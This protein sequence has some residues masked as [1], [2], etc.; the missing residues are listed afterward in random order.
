[1]KHIALLAAATSAMGLAGEAGAQSHP[2]RYRII[3]LGDLGAAQ[4]YA[5]HISDSGVAVG[6]ASATPTLDFHGVL[7][8]GA[9]AFEIAPLSGRTQS[10]AFDIGAGGRVI[11][12]SFSLGELDER[13]FAFQN[14]AT[15]DLGAFQARATGAAGVVVGSLARS[16]PGLGLVDHACVLNPGDPPG[17]PTDLGTLGGSSSRA[18]AMS[19]HTPPLIVGVSQITGDAA[20]HAALWLSGAVRDL[21]TLGG[22]H[23]CANG[24]NGGRQVVGV[25]DLPSG[26]PHAFLFGLDPAGNVTSRTD[27]GAFPAGQSAANGINDAG[28]VVGTSDSRAFIWWGGRMRDL[29]AMIP[30][31]SGW[32]LEVAQ[33]INAH[34]VIVGRGYRDGVP[35]AFM[36]EPATG[37]AADF[38]LDA[39]VNS[40]DFFD[41]LQDFFVGS[42]AADF[43]ADTVVNS[44][45]FFDFLTAFFAGCE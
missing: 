5:M 16:I 44:Q 14:G 27:L 33:S 35:L 6:M 20:A 32:R 31:A 45:D 1:M 42:A 40:Q 39:I 15:T 29:N 28:D 9:D 18:L 4:S 22:A 12:T 37:C 11:G 38:N 13:A 25:A 30:R 24:V 7:W 41:F 2:A 10:V 19:G 36:L 23:S 8:D 26:M 21:G 43:N 3:E 34:G 17:A